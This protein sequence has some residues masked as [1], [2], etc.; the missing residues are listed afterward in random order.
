MIDSRPSQ[1]SQLHSGKLIR[2]KTLLS[3][4]RGF[5]AIVL[6]HNNPAY[7]DTLITWLASDH[8]GQLIIDLKEFPA[9]PDFEH[10]FEQQTSNTPFV[11]II[12]LESLSEV[13]QQAF[14]RGVN[15]HREHLAAV[16]KNTTVLFW[17]PDPMIRDLALNAPDFWA[18]REQV[19]DFS[20]PV[21]I[22]EQRWVATHKNTTNLEK[23]AKLKRR[24][25]ILD[26][27][28]QLPENQPTQIST[29]DLQHELGSLYRETDDL[30]LAKR[31]LHKAL[32][33]FRE[34]DDKHAYARVLRDLADIQFHQGN[35]TDALNTLEKKILSWFVK[36]EDLA[37]QAETYDRIADI[38]SSRGQ[39][40]KAL[41]IREKIILPLLEK[42][43]DKKNKAI[44]MMKIADSFQAKGQF[45]DAL[46][47]FQQEVLPL[48]EQLGDIRSLLAGRT[49]LA[50]LLW[51]MDSK[52][53][54]QQIQELLNLALADAQRLQI[55][56]TAK[57]EELMQQ[58]GIPT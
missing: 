4:A 47:A 12:N 38:Q 58:M 29:A 49:N 20:L 54:I 31:H 22:S 45:D 36:L 18:W 28:E 37:E 52:Q 17:M 9:F 7:R 39:L 34:L 24:Q 51:K 15:Y 33:L 16:A 41:N 25:E 55:P 5:N 53:N 19:F 1:P 2:L 56:E 50:I 44:T 40:G 35:A 26:Y 32:A 6:Q 30:E 43:K 27:L 46:N 3:H 48:L 13:Q 14:Y 21:D 11:H 23:K 8:P 42:T 10:Q 57:I